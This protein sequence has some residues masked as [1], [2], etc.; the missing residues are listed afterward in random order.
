MDISSYK[1]FL[2]CVNEAL[3]LSSDQVKNFSYL[4]KSKGKYQKTLLNLINV[5]LGYFFVRRQTL[6]YWNIQIDMIILYEDHDLT[7]LDLMRARKIEQKPWPE[8]Q[9]ESIVD[10]FSQY[11][12][13]MEST[14]DC[15]IVYIN[16]LNIVYSKAKDRFYISNLQN[17]IIP[18]EFQKLRELEEQGTIFEESPNKY[19]KIIFPMLDNLY[20]DDS[21]NQYKDVNNHFSLSVISLE[22]LE[23]VFSQKDPKMS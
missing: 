3:F 18:K 20:V 7:L 21:V 6:D 17:I 15:K 23:I 19:F 16:S 14:L 11:V 9:V 2:S 5:Y 1:I 4:L 22:I 10:T 12:E 8:K 13:D